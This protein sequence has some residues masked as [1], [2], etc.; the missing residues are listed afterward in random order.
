MNFMNKLFWEKFDTFVNLFIL[1]EIIL[2]VIVVLALIFDWKLLEALE[3]I[4][5]K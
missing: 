2:L 3:K 4:F 1:F 5:V